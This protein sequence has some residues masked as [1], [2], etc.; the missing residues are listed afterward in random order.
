MFRKQQKKIAEAHVQQSIVSEEAKRIEFI[1]NDLKQAQSHL[2]EENNSMSE[3]LTKAQEAHKS[4][5]EAFHQSQAEL[6]KCLA[7]RDELQK[8]VDRT[9]QASLL[10]GEEPLLTRELDVSVA[11]PDE[12][13]SSPMLTDD[14]NIALQRLQSENADLKAKLATTEYINETLRASLSKAEEDLRAEKIT[15]ARDLW[16]E[17]T[18][19]VSDLPQILD[20]FQISSYDAVNE[21]KR[22]REEARSQKQNLLD[23]VKALRAELKGVLSRLPASVPL[24]LQS[25]LSGSTDE[26]EFCAQ[27]VARNFAS[28]DLRPLQ[29]HPSVLIDVVL[30]MQAEAH[31]RES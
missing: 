4:V 25:H 12:H 11:R 10:R 7:E 26:Y 21:T 28:H 17:T 30:R 2:R 20:V 18:S 3:E 23:E 16:E 9:R 22:Q 31:Q 14:G 27:E 24:L 29:A 1:L 13:K 19:L 5:L 8:I 15:R 6:D